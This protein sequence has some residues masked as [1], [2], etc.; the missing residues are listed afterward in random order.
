MPAIIQVAALASLMSLCGG[1][2]VPALRPVLPRRRGAAHWAGRGG[3]H[4]TI[5]RW[6]LRFT[7][8]LGRWPL[9]A[10]GLAW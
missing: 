9:A 6:V 1:S 4:V 3:D 7:L 10:A 5:Y 2:L 8:P